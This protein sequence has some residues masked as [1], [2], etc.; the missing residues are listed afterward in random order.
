MQLYV[1]LDKR[2]LTNENVT[3]QQR[4]DTCLSKTC[5]DS[6]KLLTTISLSS[7]TVLLLYSAFLLL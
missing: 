1:A 6:I 7:F 5:M 2:R 3:L 4:I